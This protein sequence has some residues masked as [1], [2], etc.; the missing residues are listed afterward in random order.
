[1]ADFDLS[2]EIDRYAA[3]IC[4]D[5]R[6]GKKR[7]EVKQ[8]Y[9]EH[10]E[11]A[12]YRSMMRGMSDAEAFAAACDALG[13][14]AGMQ[15]LLAV[16]HNG[17]GL[18]RYL[19]WL[20]GGVAG[21]GVVAAY[22]LV[23]NEIVKAWLELFLT[24]AAIAVGVWLVLE[25]YTWLRAIRKRLDAKKRVKAYAKSNGLTFAEH[26]SSLC[27]LF[28]R[29][30]TPEWV[31]ETERRR[32]IISL[33]PT[34]RRLRVLHL[35]ENGL[36]SYAKKGGFLLAAVPGNRL[37]RLSNPM[38]VNLFGRYVGSNIELPRGLYRTPEINYADHHSA[39]KENAHILLLSPIL[40]DI[41]LC[42]GGRIRKLSDGD[43]L[44][45]LYGDAQVFSASGFIGFLSHGE[46]MQPRRKEY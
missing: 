45:A 24:L 9:V 5:I 38:P 37:A 21:A 42:E 22:V 15:T 43:R 35:H 41:D 4:Q 20:C 8:E 23:Q 31:V 30:A 6:S 39:D 40:L 33:L 2:R 27:S 19:K 3:R 29:S 25:A 32:Y 16:A 44:P 36:Y 26:A 14:M 17:D 34:V 10:L 7:R 46:T 12:T 13:D 28:K 1:M 11:D 18:P